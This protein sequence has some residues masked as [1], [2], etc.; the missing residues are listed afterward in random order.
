MTKA[1]LVIGAGV[2]GIHAA[3]ELAN[4]GFTVYLVE[5]SPSIGGKMAQLDKTFPKL[6]CAACFIVPKMIAAGRHPNIKLFTYSD[7]KEIRREGKSFKVKILRKPRYVDEKKC[8]GCGVCAQFC[9]V[10]APNDFD[11]GI[12][13]RSAIYVPFPQAIPLIYTIDKEQCLQC[14]LCQNL[15]MVGAINHKQKPEEI[16]VEVGAVIVTTG[17][18]LYDASK[19]KEYGYGRFDN[20][21]TGLALERLLSVSGPTGGRIVRRSDGRIPKKI[22][23]VQCVGS[24]DQKAGSVYC[25]KLCC[26]YATKEAALVKKQ[27]PNVDVTIYYTDMPAFGKGFEEFYQK[28]RSEFGIK[29]LKGEVTELVETLTHNLYVHAKNVDT[30]QPMK[31][32]FDMAVLSTGLVPAAT[33]ELANVLPLKKDEG[34]FFLALNPKTDSVTTNVDGVFIAGVAEGPKDISESVEQASV[35]A[36]KAAALLK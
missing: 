15:C 13:V 25:S 14:E 26:M 31:D 34:E 36:M 19:R 33:S 4:Q 11:E 2:A 24:R 1:G 6:D 16:E 10:E 9:P 12:G 35:A 18:D 21:I 7:V 3:L 28:A 17:F 5:R 8:I 30:K 20:V 32:E 27:V 23:F 22:A 29:Y